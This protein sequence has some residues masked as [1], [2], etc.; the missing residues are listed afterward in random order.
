MQGTREL[1]RYV[2][3][4]FDSSKHIRVAVTESPEPYR[5]MMY[6]ALGDDIA[7]AIDGTELYHEV[8]THLE[9]LFSD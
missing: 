3:S 7:M 8:V 1:A 4:R 5:A 2:M 6:L 9:E